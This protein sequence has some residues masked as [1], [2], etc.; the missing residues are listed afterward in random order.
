MD[1]NWVKTC[2]FWL[3]TAFA[4]SLSGLTAQDF[5]RGDANCDGRVNEADALMIADIVLATAPIADCGL[6]SPP[7]ACC[8]DAADIDDNGEVDLKDQALLLHYLIES[9]APPPSPGPTNCGPDPTQGDLLDCSDYTSAVCLDE[10]IGGNHQLGGDCTQDGVLD[11][12]DAL[13]LLGFFYLGSPEELPCGNGTRDDPSNVTLLD[14]S[15]DGA[16]DLSDAVG[17][18][19]WLFS[20]GSPHPAFSGN[21][22]CTPIAGCTS[23]CDPLEE[24]VVVRHGTFQE[25]LHDV[26]GRVEHLSNRAIRLSNFNY[27]PGFPVPPRCVVVWLHKSLSEVREEHGAISVSADF[28]DERFDGEELIF[29]IPPEFDEETFDYV[30][31]WCTTSVINF[32]SARL[33]LGPFP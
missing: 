2:L 17:K 13:C 20:G 1:K 24:P 9:G 16:V 33:F 12:S 27:E 4:L 29:S 14:W 30:S 32:G 5:R 8:L 23:T 21:Q 25:N 7:T 31:I 22:H 15:G 26:G 3:V 19:S 11:L 18:L 6:D 28:H 10:P